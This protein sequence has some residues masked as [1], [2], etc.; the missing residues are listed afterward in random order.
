MRHHY[1]Q[2]FIISLPTNGNLPA[3]IER[4][5]SRRFLHLLFCEIFCLEDDFEGNGRGGNVSRMV[6]SRMVVS[7]VGAAG[8]PI[9]VAV[10]SSELWG[11][12]TWV[13]V[14]RCRVGRKLYHA[15]DEGERFCGSV[16]QADCSGRLPLCWCCPGGRSWKWMG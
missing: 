9:R 14:W 16:S 3:A 12:A 7:T 4:I 13:V 11:Q 8:S 6:L 15:V 10:A 2:Q 5:A 1:R